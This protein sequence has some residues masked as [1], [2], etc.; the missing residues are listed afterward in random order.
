[1]T[2]AIVDP[3]WRDTDSTLGLITLSG[4]PV[5]RLLDFGIT[6]A[7]ATT[8]GISLGSASTRQTS[9]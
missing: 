7:L 5:T 6:N 4:I 8:I 9:V 3:L 2:R 1:M